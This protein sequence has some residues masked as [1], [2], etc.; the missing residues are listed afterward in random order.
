MA[1]RLLNKNV[2][3]TAPNT[4]NGTWAEYMLTDANK[5]MDLSKYVSLEQGSMLFVNPLTAL[6]FAKK[7]KKMKADLIVFSAAGSA[8]GQMVTHFANE[9][10]VPVF[11]LIRKEKLKEDSLKKGFA[12]VFCT[13]NDDYLKELNSVVKPFKK[14]IFFDAVGGGSIPYQILNALPDNTRMV[15]YGR[16]DQTPSDFSPQNILF[17]QNTIEGYWLSKEA[18]KKSIVEVI[19]DVKKIQ[20]MLS[21]GFETQIQKKV[22]LSEFQTGLETYVKGMS[23]GKVLIDC[24]FDAPQ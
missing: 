22:K 23:A 15:I 7:V 8:L 21:K 18:Q 19:L 16:L 12:K 3:C 2:A 9:I 11:G 17:K 1:N 24:R 4:G 20:K 14:V 6:S 10:N 5:C 13:E